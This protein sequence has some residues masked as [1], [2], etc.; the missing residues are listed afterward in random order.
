[1]TLHDDQTVTFIIS[2]DDGVIEESAEWH[3]LNER[4]WQL[5]TTTPAQPGVLGLEE[6]IVEITDYEVLAFDGETM[7]LNAFD[8]EPMVYRRLHPTT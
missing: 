8:S 4:Q 2:F 7:E 5:R 1:M 6:D 3:F